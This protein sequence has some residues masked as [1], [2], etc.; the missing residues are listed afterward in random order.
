V[1]LTGVINCNIVHSYPFL[2]RMKSLAILIISAAIL[3]CT[4]AATLIIDDFQSARDVNSLGLMSSD[5]GTGRMYSKTGGKMSIGAQTT[6]TYWMTLLGVCRNISEFT[7]LYFRAFA[8]PNQRFTIVLGEGNPA[9]EGWSLYPWRDKQRMV[10]V[11]RYVAGGT[12]NGD[13]QGQ[14]VYIP[15]SHFGSDFAFDRASLLMLNGIFTIG[16]TH[17]NPYSDVITTVSIGAISLTTD[18]PT[19]AVEQPPAMARFQTNCGPGK[20]AVTFDGPSANMPR[21]M[22]IM[23]KFDGKATFFVIGGY[24]QNNPTW[25][26]YVADA[27]QRGHA[28]ESHTLSHASLTQRSY[29]RSYLVN[30]F[31]RTSDEIFHATGHRPT[32]IR[33][34]Y[35]H[36]NQEVLQVL[37]ELGYTDSWHWNIDSRDWFVHDTEPEAILQNSLNRLQAMRPD[38]LGG[39]WLLHD[40]FVES[41]DAMEPF[42]EQAKA[43]GF[44]FVSVYDCFNYSVES[45]RTFRLNI[46][47]LSS[48][49]YLTLRQQ[50][51]L[52]HPKMKQPLK[53][54]R[55]V[56]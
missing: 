49:Q 7:Y 29:N 40:E 31:Q 38:N 12:F 34:P 4:R 24:I 1:I 37:A 52:N 9:C 32:H 35:G 28:V 48:N 19:D 2:S 30:E 20:I 17:N 54:L 43:M 55:F 18:G 42:M 45:V 22:D 8:S 46:I 23:D 15:L 26:G 39:V 13:P 11:H 27:Y 5:G 3:Q 16:E 53:L 47:I 44:E 6:D 51:H 14:D 25:A 50:L 36:V 10:D 41:V 56:R 21:V 33:P